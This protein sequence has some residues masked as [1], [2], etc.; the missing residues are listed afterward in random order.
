MALTQNVTAGKPAVGGA[1]KS[2][3]IGTVLP[4]DATTALDEAFKSFK[5]WVRRTCLYGK[6]NERT[7]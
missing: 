4:T 1:I 7:K 6:T 2:A 3:P 5:R